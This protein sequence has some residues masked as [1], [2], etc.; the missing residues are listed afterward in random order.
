MT[1]N[2]FHYPTAGSIRLS[3]AYTVRFT[4]PL[5]EAM[6]GGFVHM[7]HSHKGANTLRDVS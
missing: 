1:S 7:R 5:G 6:P 2:H 3:V 4:K